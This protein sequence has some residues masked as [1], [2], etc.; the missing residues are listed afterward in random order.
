MDNR[1]LVIKAKECMPMTIWQCQNGQTL[2]L[3]DNFYSFTSQWACNKDFKI[4]QGFQNK[5]QRS[6]D[7]L[8][9]PIKMNAL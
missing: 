3:L 7:K 4:K 2:Y 9:G 1:D 8:F 6:F 5:T